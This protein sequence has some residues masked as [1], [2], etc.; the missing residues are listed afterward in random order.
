MLWLYALLSY[1]TLVV[2]A[3]YWPRKQRKLGE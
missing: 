2:L 3:T 1:C